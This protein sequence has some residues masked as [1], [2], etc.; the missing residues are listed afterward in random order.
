MYGTLKDVPDS[1][2]PSD[3]KLPVII[4]KNKDDVVAPD[5]D[6][7]H[8][9][10][11]APVACDKCSLETSDLA[12]LPRGYVHSCVGAVVPII[13]IGHGTVKHDNFEEPSASD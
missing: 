2:S 10:R 7:N 13:L 6:K 11:E 5:V 1:P 4:L 8:L 3:G 9:T 12:S